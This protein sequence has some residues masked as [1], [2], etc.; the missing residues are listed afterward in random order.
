MKIRRYEARD[1]EGIAEVYRNAVRGI[2]PVHYSA[3]Q[4]AAW[5]SLAPSAVAIH[6]RAS[7]GRTTLVAVDEREQP[8][9]FIDMEP[10]GHIDL[11]YCAPEVAG[12]GV[13]GH[14]YDA[15][16]SMARAAGMMRLYSE[17]SEA[18]LRFF[19]K[20]GFVILHRRDLKIGDVAIHNYA[21]EKP[22]N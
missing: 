3:A 12:A 15:V 16:E 8:A 13:A 10:D 2:G 11:F 7:D 18:A 20:R 4:V 22:L 17:A 21:V 5:V 6:M 19:A 1:A 9:G 14:L